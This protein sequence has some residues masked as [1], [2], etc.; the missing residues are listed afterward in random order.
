MVDLVEILNDNILDEIGGEF[1]IN[2]SEG[3]DIN[4]LGG[5]GSV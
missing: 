3:D 5:D 4:E 2:I 1:E